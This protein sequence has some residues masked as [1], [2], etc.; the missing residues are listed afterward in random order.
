MGSG[1]VANP[2]P[3]KIEKPQISRISQ[4]R[5]CRVDCG[6]LWGGYEHIFLLS[7]MVE[8]FLARI[9]SSGDLHPANL[10]RDRYQDCL[11]TKARPE[12]DFR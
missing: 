12:P 8:G 9:F 5:L 6:V 1:D 2:L 10:A 4:I 3:E 7:P 11:F